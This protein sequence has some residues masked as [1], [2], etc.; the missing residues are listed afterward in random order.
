MLLAILAVPAMAYYLGMLALLGVDL[1]SLGNP[2]SR[3]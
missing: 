2:A 3:R 1:S